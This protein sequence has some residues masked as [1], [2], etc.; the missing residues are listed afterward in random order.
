MNQ[1]VIIAKDGTDA[2]ALSRR[3]AHRPAHFELMKK[4][5]SEG[6]FISGGAILNNDGQMAGSVVKLQFESDVDLQKWISEEPYI[7]GGV[8]QSYEILPFRL[9]NLDI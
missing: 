7:L 3:M 8:W 2:D 1:Y 9:A 6:K 5:K 4:Y